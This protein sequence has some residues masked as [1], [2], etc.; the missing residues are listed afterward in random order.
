MSHSICAVVCCAVLDGAAC[1][2]GCPVSRA[3]NKHAQSTYRIDKITYQPVVRSYLYYKY[4][5]YSCTHD[6]FMVCAYTYYDFQYLLCIL[7]LLNILLFGFWCLVPGAV[8]ASGA[9]SV[10]VII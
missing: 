4:K 3:T 2:H 1:F 6:G 7:L 9:A 5:H 10:S 8:A